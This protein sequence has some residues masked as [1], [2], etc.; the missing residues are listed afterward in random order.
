M[1]EA[2]LY[3]F[4]VI[5]VKKWR[6]IQFYL[7]EVFRIADCRRVYH[8]PQS[9]S[10]SIHFTFL[11]VYQKW[12]VSKDNWYHSSEKSIIVEIIFVEILLK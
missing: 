5:E 12:L 8:V 2:H 10:Y 9:S 3:G 1:C 6:T 7:I 4:A 11:E